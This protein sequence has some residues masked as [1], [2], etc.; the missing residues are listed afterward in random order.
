MQ[1]IDQVFDVFV[2]QVQQ[3]R[4]KSWETVEIPQLLLVFSWTGCCS[5]VACNNK[6]PWSM[7]RCSSSMVVNVPVIMRDSGK[8]PR[9]RSSRLGGLDL[10]LAQRQVL[11]SQQWQ[12]WWVFD[13]FC[14]I[15]RAPPVVPECKRQFFE[16]S[17]AHKCECSRAPVG[18]PINP[19]VTW[20]YA[21]S[22]MSLKYINYNY[23]YNYN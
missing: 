5:P 19:E 23:N 8:C 12:R 15:C 2:A 16:L 20:T 22:H 4:A 11:D 18:L 3:I 1:F 10:Q 6:C 14:V 17:S 9:F 21:H 13:A 7:T